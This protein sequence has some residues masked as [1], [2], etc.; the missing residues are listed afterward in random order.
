MAIAVGVKRRILSRGRNCGA[1]H[2][3]RQESHLSGK[4]SAFT[5][6]RTK[7]KPHGK[8]IGNSRLGRQMGRGSI[9]AGED[10]R[11]IGEWIFVSIKF[12]DSQGPGAISVWHGHHEV[13]TPIVS[14]SSVII[15]IWGLWASWP[16]SHVPVPTV[17]PQ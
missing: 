11:G 4:Q 6:R 17:P 16:T 7:S 8:S 9:W 12:C 15:F 3:S 13:C 14:I 1:R 10:E 2:G 5:R